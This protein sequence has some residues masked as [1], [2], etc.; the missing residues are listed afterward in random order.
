MAL[1]ERLV[2]RSSLSAQHTAEMRPG[3]DLEVTSIPTMNTPLSRALAAAVLG[4]T[5]VSGCAVSPDYSHYDWDARGGM[6]DERD[7]SL[8]AARFEPF[9]RRT[10][11]F[12]RAPGDEPITPSGAPT[13]REAAVVIDPGAP[14][15]V[16]D[17][18]GSRRVVLASAG[19]R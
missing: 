3:S 11:A 5:F 19:E 14:A 4:L 8:A 15:P 2:H 6:V 13:A 9:Q 10:T 7:R 16:T 1:P 18:R 12:R 17:V